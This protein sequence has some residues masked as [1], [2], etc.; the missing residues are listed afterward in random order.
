MVG[1]R[2]REI[3]L[4]EVAQQ[5]VR[6]RTGSHL[7]IHCF[8]K[9]GSDANPRR[10]LRNVCRNRCTCYDVHGRESDLPFRV[11]TSFLSR[12]FFFR[13]IL[14]LDRHLECEEEGIDLLRTTEIPWNQSDG[15]IS[16]GSSGSFP[17]VWEGGT[18]IDVSRMHLVTYGSLLFVLFIE[19]EGSNGKSCFT[20]HFLDWNA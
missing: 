16:F 20:W 6:S 8:S 17:R 5:T 9:N 18:R 13:W 2:E 11:S 4:M 19:N 12:F 14:L 1:K 10:S 3:E 15:G 7:C